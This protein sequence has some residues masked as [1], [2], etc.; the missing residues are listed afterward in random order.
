MTDQL[1][2]R[3][4]DPEPRAGHLVEILDGS[5]RHIS[6]AIVETT[7]DDACVL[8]LDASHAIPDEAR[9]RWFDGTGAWQAVVTL[10]R[11][12]GA[13]ERAALTPISEW[14]QSGTRRAARAPVDKSPLLARIVHSNAL[15][16]GRRVHAICLDISQTGCRATWPGRAPALGDTVDLAW[17]LGDWD[18]DIPPGWVTAKIAR[19]VSLPFGA[20]QVGFQ[21]A[22]ENAEQEARVEEWHESWMQAYRVK[23]LSHKAA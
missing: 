23:L 13:A 10:A 20:R 22:P 21:F 5:N 18:R 7:S 4:L 8:R 12:P 11:V 6:T 16:K 9:V 15:A 3:P 2:D 17:D 19:I 1:P 14:E